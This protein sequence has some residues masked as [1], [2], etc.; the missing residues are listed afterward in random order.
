MENKEI[1]DLL[2]NKLGVTSQYLIEEM[3]K[4]Y[5]TSSLASILISLILA[6]FFFVIGYKL[7]KTIQKLNEEGCGYE[8]AI[9]GIVLTLIFAGAVICTIIFLINLHD[10]VS[11]FISPVGGTI[12]ILLRSM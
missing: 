4:Y 10:A 9:Y 8:D 3:R 11:L 7:Y 1:I 6:V 12:S 2:C 5:I